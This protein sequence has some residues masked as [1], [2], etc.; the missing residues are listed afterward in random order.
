MDLVIDANILF[1][2]LVKESSTSDIFF[3]HTLYAPEFILEEFKKY[4]DYLKGKTKRSEPGFIDFF[5]IFERTVIF[6]PIEEITPFL[7]KSEGISPDP[8]DVPYLALALKL[9]CALWSNDK[10]LKKQEVIAVYSTEELMD[11]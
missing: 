1:A 11:I 9:R 8:K 5:D 6:I 10:K 7:E 2:A 4:K 3:K